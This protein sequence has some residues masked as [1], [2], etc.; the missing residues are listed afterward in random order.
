[1][2]ICFIFLRQEFCSHCE[3]N[4]EYR[5][6]QLRSEF[7]WIFTYCIDHIIIGGLANS[8][9]ICFS[10]SIRILHTFVLKWPCHF[11]HNLEWFKNTY[12][13]ICGIL[14]EMMVIC[15]SDSTRILLTLLT[16][17]ILGLAVFSY[18]QSI[19]I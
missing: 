16:S 9:V 2:V 14:K 10:A 13:I 17:R 5:N 8:M 7:L 15:F 12:H 4:E 11:D 6:V 18:W 3:E 19:S 1:M